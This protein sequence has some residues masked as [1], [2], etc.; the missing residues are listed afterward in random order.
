MYWFDHNYNEIIY[1]QIQI[2]FNMIT[3]AVG[4][5]DLNISSEANNLKFVVLKALSLGYQTVAIN[6]VFS[7]PE[8]NYDDLSKKQK[9]QF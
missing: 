7:S 5:C 3:S 6:T 1:F 9:G 8:K 4:H 2:V